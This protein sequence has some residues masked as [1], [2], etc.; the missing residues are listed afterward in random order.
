M[1]NI[2]FFLVVLIVCGGKAYAIGK[3][4][5]CPAA[6]ADTNSGDYITP[7][8]L[9]CFSTVNAAR[10]QGYV[11]SASEGSRRLFQGTGYKNTDSIRSNGKLKLGLHFT[12]SGN[13]IVWLRDAKTGKLIELLANSIG[14]FH[15]NT[16][17]YKKGSFYLD[18]SANGSWLIETGL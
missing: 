3:Q 10:F 7:G 13:F 2:T 14:S 1:K 15:D 17:I 8:N 11:K 4:V 18:V 12:G 5:K 16:I 9:E 6:I